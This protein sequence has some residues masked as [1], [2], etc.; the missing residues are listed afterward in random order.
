MFDEETVEAAAA[1]LNACRERSL[2]LVTAESCTGG[3]VA[4][5]LTAVPGSSDVVDC[6][7]VAYSYD[8]KTKM[9]GV[10]RAPI[11]AHGAVSEQVAR[12][13]AAGVLAAHP[14]RVA[15]AVTG[16]AG[17][18]GDS[19]AKPAG[20]VHFGAGLGR[21]TLHMERRYGDIGRC[22]VRLAAV[23]DALGLVLKLLEG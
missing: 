4:G 11:L 19:Q 6:G 3:L 17:P 16:V 1:V 22:G 13:M 9:L 5:A 20:L 15:V 2:M 14:G 10:E 12:A 18:G 8:A 7:Y 23:R 21:R